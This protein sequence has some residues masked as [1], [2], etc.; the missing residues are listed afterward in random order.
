MFEA[1]HLYPIFFGCCSTRSLKYVSR[2]R[3]KLVLCFPNIILILSY[4]LFY[5][6]AKIFFKMNFEIL[7]FFLEKF[8][9]QLKKFCLETTDILNVVENF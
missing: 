3:H 8:N 5:L 9:F 1:K 2:S 4:V 6:K 7:I